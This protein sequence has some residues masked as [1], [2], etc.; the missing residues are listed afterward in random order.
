MRYEV[1]RD[2][3][4]IVAVTWDRI[5]RNVRLVWHKVFQPSPSEPLDFEATIETTLL[6]L[7]QRFRVMEVRYDPY[8]MQAVAQ[9][10]TARHVPMVEFPQSVPNLTEASTN[11][12][13]LIKGANLCVYP[14]DAMRLSVQRAVAVEMPRGW[15]IAK[16]KQSHKIDVVI[17][18]G[19]AS[20]GAVQC[21]IGHYPLNFTEQDVAAVS[22]PPSPAMSRFSRPMRFDRG[23]RAPMPMT[24]Q[25]SVSDFGA[26]PPQPAGPANVFGTVSYSDEYGNK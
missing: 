8:Q 13:E 4:A 9:R 20:L 3:T 12:Y 17:A 16:E 22:R 11:L 2:S 5:E 15:R 26:A 7:K 21:G 6:Q 19:M 18:L 14:D 25:G 1:K 23:R 24:F 10:L